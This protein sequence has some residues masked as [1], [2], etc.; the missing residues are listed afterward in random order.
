VS[1]AAIPPCFEFDDLLRFPAALSRKPMRMQL[2]LNELGG[3]IPI[4]K[5]LSSAH[6]WLLR[7]L[8][9][10]LEMNITKGFLRTDE[11]VSEYLDS[12][13][14]RL[15]QEHIER[16]MIL[17]VLSDCVYSSNIDVFLDAQSGSDITISV[18]NANTAMPLSVLSVC[19]LNPF[20]PSIRPLIQFL[21]DEYAPTDTERIVA[22]LEGDDVLVKVRTRM[23]TAQ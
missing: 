4:K 15:E 1:V 11:E 5:S 23:T 10:S 2:Q 7:M 9:S 8:E 17:Q 20:C 16:Q 19:P 18:E 12:N 6:V 13:T 21:M 14:K 3:R 22:T